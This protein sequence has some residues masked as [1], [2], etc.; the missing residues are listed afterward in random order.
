MSA[1]CPVCAKAD[2]DPRSCD[3]AKVPKPDSCTAANEHLNRSALL[4][5]PVAAIRVTDDM[6]YW[7]G[8]AR[9]LRPDAGELDY[10]APL[11]NLG[12]HMVAEL[13]GSEDF[14][15][16]GD[17]RRPRLD[18][19]VHQPGIDLA[20]EALDDFGWRTPWHADPSPY[21]RLVAWHGVADGRDIR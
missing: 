21:A 14:L 4:D 3:V 5:H 18:G 20:V 10:S 2:V 9:S 17:F 11:L 6:E 7:T 8:I 15:R 16:S 13:R 19:R 12:C 1:Q